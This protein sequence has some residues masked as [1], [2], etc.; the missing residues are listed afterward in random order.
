MT[1]QVQ[2]EAALL[3]LPPTAAQPSGTRAVPLPRG[4]WVLLS[5]NLIQEPLVHFLVAG[6]LILAGSTLV[7]RWRAPADNR[8]HIVVSAAQLQQLKDVWVQQWGRQPDSEET[9]NLVNDYVREEVLYR[10]ALA[11]GLD[12]DDTIVRRRLVEKMEFLSQETVSSS[13]PTDAELQNFLQSN[14]E[15]YVTPAQLSFSHIYFSTAKRTIS[16]KED[17]EKMLTNLRAGKISSARA[18][19]QGDAFIAES[20]YPLEGQD[21]IANIFGK[22]FASQ[23]IGLQ[24]GDW[25]GPYESSYGFHL[26]RVTDR[27]VPRLPQLQQIR[28]QVTN[29]WK[30]QQLK[31]ASDAY[32]EQLRQRYR[33]DIDSATQANANGGPLP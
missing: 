23:V 25:Q 15:R 4:R 7:S 18:A 31:E 17:A 24:P 26:V 3:N 8:Y 14:K 19:E 32:Y 1:T 33:V 6:A 2:Q 9:Q 30:T 20:D 29:D 5:R 12:K 10:E 16:A 21:D 28:Q 22:D 27:T 13:E 11:S